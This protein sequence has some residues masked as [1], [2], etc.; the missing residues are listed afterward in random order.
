MLV[1]VSQSANAWAIQSALPLSIIH[2]Y[3]ANSFFDAFIPAILS[4]TLLFKIL[5]Y[6]FFKT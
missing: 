3:H 5:N 1:K 4:P 2:I 6:I